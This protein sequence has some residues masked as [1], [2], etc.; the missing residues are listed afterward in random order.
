M[1]DSEIRPAGEAPLSTGM[2][3]GTMGMLLTLASIAC[4]FGALVVAY[5]FILPDK[6]TRASI[7]I[8]WFFW[9]STA[10][11][12]VSSGTLQWARRALRRAQFL[13]YRHRLLVTIAMGYLFLV[14][15]IAGAWLLLA[16]GV[17]I[18]GNPQ[19]NMFYV[20]SFIHG[21]HLI[22]GIGGMHWLYGRSKKLEDGEEQPLRR[23]RMEARLTGMYWHFMGVLWIGL[24]AFLLGWN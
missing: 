21:A 23:H 17:T 15:Q 18:S 9:L 10:L 24:F 13:L 3:L 20:F 22:G 1:T 14:A 5:A 16:S 2:S 12:L 4:F 19:G 6:P 8:P 7:A 11:M